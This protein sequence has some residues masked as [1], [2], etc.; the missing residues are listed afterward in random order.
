VCEIDSF[1]GRTFSE[2]QLTVALTFLSATSVSYISQ[3]GCDASHLAMCTR[4]RW[5]GSRRP[6]FYGRPT[7]YG[8]PLY[9]CPVVSF[10]FYLSLFPRLISAV[11]EWLS[12]IPSPYYEDMWRRYCCLTD[13]FRLSIH[14]LVAKIQP[15]KW[16]GLSANLECRSEMCCT[17]LAGN[18][19]R[20]NDAKNRHLRTMAQLCRA[21]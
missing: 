10:F 13:F 12:T 8:R 15:C 9:F 5:F 1:V 21:E 2:M 20:K 19:G 18:T 14:A 11:A 4:T 7:V 17:R 3:R 6:V 16:C